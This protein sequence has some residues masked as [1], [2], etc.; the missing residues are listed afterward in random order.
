MTCYS[1]VYKA[2]FTL[3]HCST[4]VNKTQESMRSQMPPNIAQFS[5]IQVRNVNTQ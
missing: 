5:L 4:T 2:H 3:M 1:F